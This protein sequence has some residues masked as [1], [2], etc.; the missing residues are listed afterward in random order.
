MCQDSNK[1][2]GFTLV[3]LMMA[4]AFLS[5]LLI[6]I[7]LTVIQIV[8]IYNKGITMKE[9]DQAARTISAD[10]HQTLS[11]SEPFLDEDGQSGISTAYFCLQNANG[12]CNTGVAL[13]GRLC[14]G[15]YSYVWN[16]KK[17]NSSGLIISSLNTYQSSSN[18][19]RFVRVRDAGGEYCRDLSKK[20]DS[21]SQPTELLPDKSG[22]ILESFTINKVA[23]DAS[24]GTLY[25]IVM[26][27]GTDDPEALNTLDASC[28]PPKDIGTL[29]NYCSVN[30]LDFTVLAGNKG[31]NT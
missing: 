9:V 30:Q 13:G 20:I 4:M 8:N 7:A 1:S 23:G 3:E 25:H 17:L 2:K 22:L 16:Y 26:E 18:Q 6:V 15:A 12:S 5:T 27:I 21:N 10:F 28:K 31:G 14:T 24:N 19:L 11:Q 29:Q